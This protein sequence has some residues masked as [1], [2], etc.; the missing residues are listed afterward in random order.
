MNCC[1]YVAIYRTKNNEKSLHA[2]DA[3]ITDGSVVL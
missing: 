3:Y 1:T 2:D